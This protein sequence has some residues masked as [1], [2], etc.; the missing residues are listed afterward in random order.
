MNDKKDLE[1][2]LLPDSQ[3]LT[4]AGSFVRR[5]SLDEIP[6]LI[7]VLK[8]DMS[9]I[10]PRPL[11]PRYLPYYTKRE[12]KRHTVKPGI[13]GLAQVTGRNTINWDKKLDLDAQYVENMS[14]KNDISILIKTVI[15]VISKKDVVVIPGEMFTTLDN[16]RKNAID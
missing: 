8:G 14:L 2:N 10:G 9:L 3:R 6:Q 11:L 16:Y 4:K 13:T 1:G 15:S 12:Q 7:N 5:T